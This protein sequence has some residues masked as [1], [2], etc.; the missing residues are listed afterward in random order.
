MSLYVE[1]VVGM[2]GGP[3]WKAVSVCP[4]S[5]QVGAGKPPWVLPCCVLVASRLGSSPIPLTTTRGEGS[6][7]PLQVRTWQLN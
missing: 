4:E 6:V 3:V 2:P 1:E 5:P 7:T